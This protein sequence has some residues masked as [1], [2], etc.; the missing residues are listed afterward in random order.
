MPTNQFS[1]GIRAEYI[2]DDYT[3]S[4]IGLTD[5]SQTLATL[6]ATYIPRENV[7]T[8]AYY[9]Y[10]DIQS[11]QAGQQTDTVTGTPA[12]WEA[13]FDDNINTV[14]IGATIAKLN[15][16]WDIGADLTYSEATGAI[17]MSSTNQAVTQYPDLK[18]TLG[19]IK[20]WTTYKQ[21]KKLSYK[22][23]YWYEDYSADNWALDGIDPDTVEN[24]LLMGEDTLDYDVHVVGASAIYSF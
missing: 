24:M 3:D 2:E 16:K 13:D 23:S 15:N 18:T 11:K 5:A 4:E 17:D 1:F 6:D 9:T 14:G 21:S 10:E 19:S 8:Y 20:L 12:D 22:F 7:T